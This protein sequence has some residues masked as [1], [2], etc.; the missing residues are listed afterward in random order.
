M[1]RVKA[2]GMIGTHA[3]LHWVDP[4]SSNDIDGDND[5]EMLQVFTIDL[6]MMASRALG[7][8][9]S[10]M[11]SYKLHK[12]T[13]GVRPVDDVNDN[14][15]AS[16]FAGRYLFHHAT[17]HAKKALQLARKTEKAIEATAV[18][19]DSLFLSTENDYSGFR[20]NWSWGPDE[21]VVEFAT[22]NSLPTMD[23]RWNLG[24][25]EQAY[26][27]MTSSNK[28]NKLFTGRFPTAQQAIWNCGWSNTPF[29]G[30]SAGEGG[31]IHVGD[32]IT[33]FN[34]DILP[35][36][37]GHINYSHVNEPGTI[38]DDYYVWVDVEFTVGGA[39]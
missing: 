31:S 9:E 17:D 38:D 26:N 28:D 10:M 13:I 15:E 23:E 7:R 12:I 30:D 34:V 24:E 29:A 39:F 6:S 27:L 37:R 16:N 33:T 5:G 8:Q 14:E 4:P 20:Y 25:I 1:T 3:G 19:A 18:D 32:G 36:V 22:V 35:L 2:G 21:Q 11:K